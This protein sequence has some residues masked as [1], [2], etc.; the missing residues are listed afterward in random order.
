M[1]D[2]LRKPFFVVAVTLLAIVVV[3]ELVSA[4][5][6]YGIR[7]MAI[8]DGLLLFTILLIGAP[9]L[10]PERIHGRTQ[11]VVTLIFSLSTLVG[12]V[13]MIIIAFKLL[14]L[15]VSLFMAIP[16]GTAIYLDTYSKFPKASAAAILSL[17]MTFKLAFAVL[18]IL[19]HQ[20]FIENKGLV[21]LTLTSLL[22]NVLISFLHGL[23]PVFLVSI[24]DDIGALIV[25]VLAAIWALIYLIGS[26][27]AIVKALRVD[28]ALTIK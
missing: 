15:M 26:I 3:T 1:T 24:T 13:V 23:F 6:G 14:T 4:A 5:P 27:P 20:R 2:A 25:A 18:L 9:L 19:A 7:Y 17:T 21:T 12:A 10:I 11:G 8:L 22:A 28:R 16:F